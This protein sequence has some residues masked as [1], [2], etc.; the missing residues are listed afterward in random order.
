MYNVK[1]QLTR[2]YLSHCKCQIWNTIYVIFQLYFPNIIFSDGSI[3][4]ISPHYCDTDIDI[5]VKSRQVF[6]DQLEMK[7]QGKAKLI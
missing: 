7:S 4:R 1:S 3:I 2:Y 5:D 6:L